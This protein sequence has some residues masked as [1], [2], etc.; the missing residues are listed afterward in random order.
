MSENKPVFKLS[1][2]RELWNAVPD[3]VLKILR[4]SGRGG[5]VFV[6]NEAKHKAVTEL[7]PEEGYV[8]YDCFACQYTRIYG[9]L[10]LDEAD[11]K[12]CEY[13]PL[14]WKDGIKC[15][16]RGNP[17]SL[18]E[19]MDPQKLN[20]TRLRNICKKI[21]ELPVIEGVETE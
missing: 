2:H 6:L 15:G 13:C 20:E 3:Y 16:Y 10:L 12:N 14:A 17:L 8:V 21:A 9:E 7:F 4:E 1:K 11:E 18:L 19:R 5:M